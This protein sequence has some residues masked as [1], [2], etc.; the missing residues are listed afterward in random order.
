ME[1]TSW[2]CERTTVETEWFDGPESDPDW[3]EHEEEESL[4]SSKVSAILRRRTR[5]R[6]RPGILG[7]IFLV[8]VKVPR[9]GPPQEL[10]I[11]YALARRSLGPKHQLKCIVIPN[12]QQKKCWK[13]LHNRRFLH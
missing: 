4:E 3:D 6:G 7:G 13:Q 2:A 12:I 11:Q 1:R 10:S 5:L 9:V 8:G